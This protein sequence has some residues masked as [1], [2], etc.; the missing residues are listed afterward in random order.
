[1][2]GGM[3]CAHILF[4]NQVLADLADLDLSFLPSSL[5]SGIKTPYG[6]YLAARQI[7]LLHYQWL[8]VNDH[9][10]VLCGQEMVDSVLAGGNLYYRPPKGDGYMPVEFSAAAYRF[11]HSTVRPSYRANFTSG[12]GAVSRP[13]NDAF[14]GL[15]FDPALPDF[16]EPYDRD[17][18][19]GGYSA[20]R[21][22]LG[23]QSFFD[24][25]DGQVLE[26]KKIDT[27]ISTTLFDLPV[28]AIPAE[29]QH[30]PVVLPQRTLLR[31]LTWELPSGQEV[32]TAMG[33]A[34]LTTDDLAAIASVDARLAVSTPL[35]YYFLAE[36][37]LATGGAALGP[38]GGRIVAETLIGLLRSD[39]TSY[40]SRYPSFEPFL[41]T[42]FE[43]GGAYSMCSFLNYAGV[44]EPGVYR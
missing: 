6:Q 28:P 36:A 21:R 30:S 13:G 8:L 44:L 38:A 41:G 23:W 26:A 39:P 31:Q 16:N 15:V 29:T 24:A 2:I 14:V 42:G 32:A 43:P 27:I 4:Y 25:G 35:W 7:T 17:D 9:L 11:G 40:L 12:T 3:H 10:P 5:R 22:Y 34:P 18:L 37:E 19:L 20:P 33:L 1:M